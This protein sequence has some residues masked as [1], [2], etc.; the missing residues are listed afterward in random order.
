[1]VPDCWLFVTEWAVSSI[2]RGSVRSIELGEPLLSWIRLGQIKLEVLLL[3]EVC[4][5]ARGIEIC[6]AA[7]YKN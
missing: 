6:C 7:F 5:F 4:V 1:M 3:V 2:L